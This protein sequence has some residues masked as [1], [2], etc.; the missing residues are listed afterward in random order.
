MAM[1]NELISIMN[2][3]IDLEDIIQLNTA[4]FTS[5]GKL[6][7]SNYFATKKPWVGMLFKQPMCTE[8][9]AKENLQKL[10]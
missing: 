8:A 6:D 1:S 3:A 10:L 5:L 4:V 2:L 9:V 7:I